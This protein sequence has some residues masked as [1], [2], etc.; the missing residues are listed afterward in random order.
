M[1]PTVL[2]YHVELKSSFLNDEFQTAQ[3]YMPQLPRRL[4]I[5]YMHPI[6]E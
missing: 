4:G 2:G 1:Y 6:P 3:A 5:A